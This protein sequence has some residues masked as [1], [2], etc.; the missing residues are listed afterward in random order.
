MSGASERGNGRASGPV[1]QSV[2]L[3]AIDHSEREKSVFLSIYEEI[4]LT[5]FFNFFGRDFGKID[6]FNPKNDRG[7]ENLLHVC[8]KFKVALW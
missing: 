5:I 7:N 3:A 6:A 8:L 2:F 1:L 4:S